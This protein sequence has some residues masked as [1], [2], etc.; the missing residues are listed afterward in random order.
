VKNCII[1]TS[2]SLGNGTSFFLPDVYHDIV[3]KSSFHHPK[4]TSI[5]YA[6]INKS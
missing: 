4:L 6:N 3:R 5:P 2:E 1:C